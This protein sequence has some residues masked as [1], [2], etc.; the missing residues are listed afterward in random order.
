MIHGA[1]AQSRSYFSSLPYLLANS[2]IA[3][4]IYDKR[5][6]GQSTGN[7]RTA[8]MADFA[9]DALAGVRLLRERSDI[10]P[11]LVGVY[12]H[13]QGGWQ[14]PL[15]AIRSAGAVAFVIT[16]AGPAKEY[17]AQTNDE[18]ANALRSAG[19]SSGDIRSA[20]AHQDLYWAVMRHRASWS[21][22]VAS[23]ESV[24]KKPWGRYVWKPKTE[25]EVLGDTLEYID[26]A[27][28]LSRLTVPILAMY[29]AHDIRVNG[30]ENAQLMRSLLARA[31]NRSATVRIFEHADHDFWLARSTTIKDV[32]GTTGYVP[33]YLSGI[34]AWVRS[35][36]GKH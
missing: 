24:S 20:L 26:P 15:A 9:E 32:A 12:G 36:T 25:S 29:G 4:L 6:V 34:V 31:G 35:R 7:R 16:A 23:I 22:L 19:F 5:G 17:Q 33:S 1:G 2:G 8:A 13:S 28:V 21:A 27:P 3:A 10:N 11:R 18:I 14:A 30:R